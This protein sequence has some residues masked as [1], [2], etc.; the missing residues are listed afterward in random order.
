MLV[1]AFVTT[2]GMPVLQHF[3]LQKKQVTQSC[4]MHE[5]KTC[6]E[7]QSEPKDDCC[8]DELSF[9]KFSSDYVLKTFKTDAPV[10]KIEFVLPR[11]IAPRIALKNPIDHTYDMRGSPPIARDIP[12]F[13]QSFLI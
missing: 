6:C 5:A 2:M 11:E 10:L 1:L 3:C 4:S 9:K 13:I 8:K 7:K 12:V